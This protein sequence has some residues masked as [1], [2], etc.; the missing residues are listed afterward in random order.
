M[1]GRRV[2]ARH[3]F[4]AVAALLAVG[5]DKAATDGNGQSGGV[6]DAV[7]EVSPADEEMNAAR[8]QAI[9][10]LPSFYARFADPAAD[11]TEFMVK[12]DILPGEDNEYVW[13]GQLDRSS[14]PMT[15]VLMNQPEATEHALGQRVPIPEGDIID[16]SYRKGRVVQGG[17]T[18]R[19][20]LRHMPADEAAAMRNQLGW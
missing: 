8:R 3:L 13:A 14:T 15:G 20:L 18:S 5:C 19:A 11:E 16:W 7:Y 1:R 6:T 10:S 12:F 17:F 4:A 2:T 9:G